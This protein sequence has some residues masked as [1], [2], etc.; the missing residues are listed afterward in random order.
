MAEVFITPL[1][2]TAHRGT[3]RRV[4]TV[5]RASR[6][7]SPPPAGPSALARSRP[8]ALAAVCLVVLVQ[9]ALLLGLGVAWVTDLMRGASQL[10][11]ATAFLVLF[12]LGIAAVLIAGARGLWRGRRWARSPVMTWQLLLVVMAIGWLGA[13]PTVWAMAVL[14]SALVV[15]VG[16][17]LPPV[18]AATSGRARMPDGGGSPVL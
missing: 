17:L 12:A 6:E 13:E 1:P 9:G 11:G 10:P 7:S 18:V 15:A 16:L 8:A 4:V 2:A 5:P 3:R 14:A